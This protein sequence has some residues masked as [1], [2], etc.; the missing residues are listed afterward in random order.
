MCKDDIIYV[1]VKRIFIYQDR[2]NFILFNILITFRNFV[3]YSQKK[4]KNLIFSKSSDNDSEM[5]LIIL[6]YII[7][8]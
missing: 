2:I 7:L 3:I 6:Y 5:K 4:S 8:R 1:C